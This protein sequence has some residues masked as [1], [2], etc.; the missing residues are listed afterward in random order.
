MGKG[1][2]RR[3]TDRRIGPN[4]TLI[5]HKGGVQLPQPQPTPQPQQQPVKE[6]K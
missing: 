4:K 5:P 2:V 3:T 6:A 1:S